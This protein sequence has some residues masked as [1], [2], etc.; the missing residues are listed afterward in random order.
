MNG[1]EFD[2][3]RRALGLSVA[4]IAKIAGLANDRA[5]NRWIADEAPVPEDV[6]AKL[7]EI[8]SAMHDMVDQ[9]ADAAADVTMAGPIAIRRYRTQQNLDASP[10][11]AGLPLGAHA[12]AT[13]W[14]VE[15]LLD[16]GITSAI[17]WADL[18]AKADPADRTTRF[19]SKQRVTYVTAVE[20]DTAL[21]ICMKYGDLL[22]DDEKVSLN[23]LCMA[24]GNNEGLDRDLYDAATTIMQRVRRAT[25]DG[26][27]KGAAGP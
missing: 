8:E 7:D 13:S 2:T 11:A 10:D 24:W 27:R 6:A 25:G 19:G 4:E 18:P 3:R 26:R 17:T 1:A 16:E 15:R 23:W 14:L 21:S 22:T 20:H 5:V 12:M 9:L